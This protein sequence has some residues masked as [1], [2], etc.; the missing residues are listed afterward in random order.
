MRN[1]VSKT[2][3]KN[4]SGGYKKLR[5]RVADAYAGLS[6]KEILK[7]TKNE[8]KYRQF[9]IKFTNKAKPCPVRVKNVHDQHQIDLVDMRGMKICY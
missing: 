9:S 4:K 7:V 2:F 8:L 6:S 3:R 1:I 5:T